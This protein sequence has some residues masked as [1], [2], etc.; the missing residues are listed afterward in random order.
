MKFSLLSEWCQCPPRPEEGLQHHGAEGEIRPAAFWLSIP[1]YIL[2][3]L[4]GRC[5]NLSR[6]SEH[7][8][9]GSGDGSAVTLELW[10]KNSVFTAWEPLPGGRCRDTRY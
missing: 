5:F 4:R 3:S 2:M 7:V 10:R 6:V 9:G 1:E 8:P